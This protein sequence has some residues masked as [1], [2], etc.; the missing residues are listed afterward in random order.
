[1]TADTAHTF[2]TNIKNNPEEIEDTLRQYEPDYPA[3]H[4]IA[5][6]VGVVTADQ[7]RKRS[8]QPL[9]KGDYLGWGP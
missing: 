2:L 1:M 9:A 8:M 7:G 5:F 3:T 4:P 6:P